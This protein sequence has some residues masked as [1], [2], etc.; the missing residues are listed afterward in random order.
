M[1]DPIPRNRS[2]HGR[3][4]RR[5]ARQRGWRGAFRRTRDN[6]GETEPAAPQQCQLAGPALYMDQ[7]LRRT[8]DDAEQTPQLPVPR[9]D[10]PVQRIPHHTEQSPLPPPPARPAI[11]RDQPSQRSG[12][13]PGITTEQPRP[14]RRPRPR[15]TR[16]DVAVG[17]SLV[18]G[19]ALVVGLVLPLL[20]SDTPALWS[21]APAASDHAGVAAAAPD[22]HH[23]EPVEG[24]LVAQP[25]AVTGINRGPTQGQIALLADRSATQPVVAIA[26]NQAGAAAQLPSPA[27]ISE[28]GRR[29]DPPAVSQGQPHTGQ[30]G[31]T[32]YPDPGQ[33]GG[34]PVPPAGTPDPQSGPE[35]EAIARLARELAKLQHSPGCLPTNGGGT[36]PSVPTNTGASGTRP[37]A[38][39]TSTATGG[40][41]SSS[42]PTSTAT[43][44]R[45]GG[46]GNGGALNGG[47]GNSKTTS[48]VGGGGTGGFSHSV[49]SGSRQSGGGSSSGSTGSR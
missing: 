47:G 20:P 33:H 25:G 43:G 5:L 44:A 28:P 21:S 22:G 37:P 40:T 13:N 8:R 3:R 14:P 17:V 34:P 9:P 45:G 38:A 2:A 49:S 7:P 42:V 41:R 1:P 15:R 18:A 10:Q 26:P 48:G 4:P 46:G 32:G 36:S 23:S 19:V 16:T 31:G 24:P 35:R 6:A 12:I 30:P 27:G 39:P 29:V 11:R